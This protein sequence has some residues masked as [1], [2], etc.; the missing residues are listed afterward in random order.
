[1]ALPPRQWRNYLPNW[2]RAQIRGAIE[3]LPAQIQQ[4][5]P[6]PDIRRTI[7][8]HPEDRDALDP[9]WH[10]RVGAPAPTPEESRH[11]STYIE[12]E[13]AFAEHGF[14]YLTP[15]ERARRVN[16]RGQLAGFLFDS[17]IEPEQ[18]S[19]ALYSGIN[20]E[21]RTRERLVEAMRRR[22]QAARNHVDL[23]PLFPENINHDFV[24]ANNNF[25]RRTH[26]DYA[27]TAASGAWDARPEEGRPIPFHLTE[28]LFVLIGRIHRSVITDETYHTLPDLGPV[29]VPGEG[30]PI[31]FEP[32]EEGE[33]LLIIQTGEHR[34]IFKRATLEELL[35]TSS[36]EFEPLINPFT[37]QIITLENLRRG[38]ASLRY[39]TDEVYNALQNLGAVRVPVEDDPIA[40]EP[41]VD[42][43]PL[44]IIQ[45]GEHMF[46]FKRATLETW[47]NNLHRNGEPL[48]NPSTRQIIT[49]ENLR[50][51]TARIGNTGGRRRTRRVRRSTTRRL[52]RRAHH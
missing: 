18:V 10:E 5:L 37:E 22:A 26:S 43:E 23:N 20:A 14:D 52:A 46:Y 32:F 25:I 40:F 38:T 11:R 33:P 13:K 17:L 39:I 27:D 4:Y 48:T 41:F 21:D 31:S 2:A 49:I 28:E 9:G 7:R 44:L 15:R 35:N 30:D 45:T 8:E 3:L 24:N 1:M 50:R 42:G 29:A 6:A 19:Q 36:L 12:L 34:F 16:A 47:L 51:G